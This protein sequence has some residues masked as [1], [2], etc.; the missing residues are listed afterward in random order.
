[1]ELLEALRLQWEWGADEALLDA[2]QDRRH[3]APPPPAPENASPPPARRAAPAPRAAAMPA[4]PAEA[5]AAAAAC[6]SLEELETAMRNFTGCAL[7]DTATQLVFADGA[8]D[9][10]LIIVG[11]APG[12]EEDRAG[13]PF[14]GPAGQLL[15]KMLGS[16]GL[17]RTKVRI[18]NTVPWRPPGNRNPTEAEITL[19]L[20]FL[21]RQIAL[22]AP[23]GLM[24]LGAVAAKALLPA[25]GA[26]GIRRL[27]GSWREAEIDGLPAPLP[28][29]A[30]YHPA[31][32][33]R[34][35]LAKA[36]AW[37]D[38]LTLKAWLETA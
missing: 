22:I 3:A 10:R 32:L 23:R 14:V 30:T 26:T 31:Y 7:R 25:E 20:P 12:G 16:I 6:Q 36:E 35:P 28:C 2:P 15:D 34:T 38:M 33:L 24:A 27:R 9:A 18:I 8:A 21:H 19:C 1:M 17:D 29:L 11:E 4:G 13:K 5:R 37:R